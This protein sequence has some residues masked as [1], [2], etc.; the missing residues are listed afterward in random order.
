[1]KIFKF[2]QNDAKCP[3]F[4]T[5]IFDPM[6]LFCFRVY[7]VNI[8]VLSAFGTLFLEKGKIFEKK[9]KKRVESSFL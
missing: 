2:G 4:V 7:G 3:N 9:S 8:F 1:M 5:K 6:D